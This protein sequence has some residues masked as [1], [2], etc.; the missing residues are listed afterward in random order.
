MLNIDLS[1]SLYINMCIGHAESF[2]D[3][4]SHNFLV[5]HFQILFLN[6]WLTAPTDRLE[7]PTGRLTGL[8]S[9]S[10]IQ[11]RLNWDLNSDFEFDRYLV[12]T[13][14]ANRYHWPT[15]AGDWSVNLTLTTIAKNKRQ[16]SC[17]MRSELQGNDDC[18][19]GTTSS[20]MMASE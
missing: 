10:T 4:T 5:H 12:V 8:T 14:L 15:V 20:S 16:R 19:E 1:W 17:G 7:A 9:W 2:I 18:T 13:G 11:N 6:D 3:F